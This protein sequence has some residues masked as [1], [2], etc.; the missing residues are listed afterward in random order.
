MKDLKLPAVYLAIALIGSYM[1]IRKV[2]FP[3][4][5][6]MFL[7]L[8]ALSYAMLKKFSKPLAVGM[9]LL[10]ATLLT[11]FDL[12]TSIDLLSLSLSSFVLYYGRERF[13]VDALLLILSILLFGVTVLEFFLFPQQINPD[14]QF[15]PALLNLKWG[16]FFFSS[17]IFSL[18]I[19]GITSLINRE[20]FNIRAV[21]FGFFP[22]L[23]FLISGFLTLIPSL[24]HWIK[25]TSGNV[26]VG[27]FGLF[28]I[29]GFSIFIHFTDRLSPVGKFLFFLFIFIFPAF[30]FGAAVV[31]GIFDFWFDF[32]KLK[33]GKSDGSYPA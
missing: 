20:S 1:A 24:P 17:A 30:V 18:A 27:T 9:S 26:L 12:S 6:G 19:T 4:A 2:F 33:G 11:A 16:I 25:T 13:N 22:V 21:N 29:Q 7:F 23:L 15:P 10:P 32:R 14:G 3:F 28:A 5:L 31:A 8:P